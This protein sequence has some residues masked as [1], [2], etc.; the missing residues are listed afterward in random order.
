MTL[1]QACLNGNRPRADHPAVPITPEELAEAARGA[2][3]AGAAE[4]HAHPRGP[5]EQD[6]VEPDPVAA[7]V[8]AIRAACPST[9]SR[10]DDRPVDDGRR[11]RAQARAR[12][13]L[14]GAA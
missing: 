2:V 7:A 13:R 14:G 8:E 11:R 4:L 9:P 10:P 3:A 5:D 6:T 1:L 12:R